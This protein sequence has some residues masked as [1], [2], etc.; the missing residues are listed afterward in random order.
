MLA[1]RLSPPV[2]VLE[3]QNN[4]AEPRKELDSNI[5]LFEA[6][7][8]EIRNQIFEYYIKNALKPTKIASWSTARAAKCLE[9]SILPQWHGPARMRI[10]GIGPLGL[11]FVNKHVLAE[12]GSLIYSKID[13]VR[14]GGYILQYRDDD[15]RIPFGRLYPLLLNRQICQFTR[16]VSLKLPSTREDLHRRND[17]LRGFSVTGFQSRLRLQDSP[18]LGSIMAVIPG[19]VE[20]LKTFELLES[21]EITITVE[22]TSPPDFEPLFP[23]YDLCGNRTTVVFID[24]TQCFGIDFR[25]TWWQW[26][27]RWDKSWRDC[28]VRHRGVKLG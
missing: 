20:C 28:L 8:G 15:P 25:T 24:P 5:S 14:I 9:L 13:D 12:L 18:N 3:V 23:L 22:M 7:P 1:E 4:T 21:L 27:E 17:S 19:L 11:L 10:S 16:C 6:L 2:N 26:T